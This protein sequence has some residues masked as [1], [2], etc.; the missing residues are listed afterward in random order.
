MHRLI[1]LVFNYSLDGFLADRGT[2]FWKFC[3]ELLDRQGGADHDA[4]TLDFLR[5]ASTHLMGRTAYEGM[6]ADLPAQP[7]HPWADIVNRGRK[8]VLSHTLTTASWANTT[9]VR[10]GTAEEVER[11]RSG[12]DGHVVV[13]G[14]DR[15]WRSLMQL[16]LVDEWHFSLY[17]STAKSTGLLELRYRRPR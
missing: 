14:G 2:E 5:S 15:L 10:G 4:R 9:I 12:G 8:V 7:E 17:P 6:S 3:F 11:L 13:W 16:D 1:A